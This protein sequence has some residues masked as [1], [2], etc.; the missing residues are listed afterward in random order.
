MTSNPEYGKLSV[1]VAV[2]DGVLTI[3]VAEPSAG[4]TWLVFDNFTLTYS[5][6]D[7]SGITEVKSQYDGN[8]TDGYIYDLQGRRL[9]SVPQK[10]LYIRNGKKYLVK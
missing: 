10:G 7:V 8:R 9:T 6:S 3:G 2:T 5:S 1:D 4:T